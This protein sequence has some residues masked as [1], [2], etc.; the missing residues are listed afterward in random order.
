MFQKVARALSRVARCDAKTNSG[1][2]PNSSRKRKTADGSTEPESSSTPSKRAKFIEDIQHCVH[3]DETFLASRNGAKSCHY[4]PEALEVNY[5]SELWADWPESMEMDTPHNRKDFPEKFRFPCCGKDGTGARKG[6]TAAQHEAA[7]G[8]SYIDPSEAASSVEPSE[9]SRPSVRFAE[10]PQ[11]RVIPATMGSDQAIRDAEAELRA[12]EKRT[13]TQGSAQG[14]RNAVYEKLARERLDAAIAARRRELESQRPEGERNVKEK[15]RSAPASSKMEGAPPASKQPSS[16]GANRSAVREH[17]LAPA[18]PSPPPP[19]SKRKP[20]RGEFTGAES[21]GRMQKRH[22]EVW[23][24]EMEDRGLGDEDYFQSSS[25]AR[26]GTEQSRW[27][28]ADT[29]RTT[30]PAPRATRQAAQAS[31]TVHR[32]GDRGIRV[33]R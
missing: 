27:A 18:A 8:Y 14:I 11:V 16:R 29:M 15:R 28:T 22:Q 24:Q 3:C 26:V 20:V 6:C 25:A 21:M 7:S 9:A 1:A 17:C 13:K 4:H 5:D 31:S 19:P 10:N 12:A 33:Q 2:A 30:V 23:R 32:G